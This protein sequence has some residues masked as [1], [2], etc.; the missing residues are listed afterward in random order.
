MT[1]AAGLLGP[2]FKNCSICLSLQ[3]RQTAHAVSKTFSF[4]KATVMKCHK[5]WLTQQKLLGSHVRGWMSELEVCAGQ[6][7]FWGLRKDPFPPSLPASGSFLLI[8]ALL[9]SPPGVLCA[10]PPNVACISGASLIGRP[11]LLQYD[12]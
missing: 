6:G 2:R 1:Q 12:I 8:A 9:Q 4:V 11:P 10:S 5:Q 7:S 3:P